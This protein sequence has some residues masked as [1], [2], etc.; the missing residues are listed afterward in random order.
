MYRIKFSFLL[1]PTYISN[2]Q[3]KK[4]TFMIGVFNLFIFEITHMLEFTFLYQLI[5]FAIFSLCFLFCESSY[6]LYC[7]VYFSFVLN[8]LFNIYFQ[9]Y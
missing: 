6:V 2:T 3:S 4:N 9:E 1:P 7:L 5:S 8:I